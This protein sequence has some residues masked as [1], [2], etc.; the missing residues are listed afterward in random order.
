MYDIKQ[1]LFT[2]ADFHVK[3]SARSLAFSAQVRRFT[4]NVN[5]CK[6]VDVKRYMRLGLNSSPSFSGNVLLVIPYYCLTFSPDLPC[7]SLSCDHCCLYYW[8]ALYF[9]LLL[10]YHALCCLY[11]PFL[12]FVMGLCCWC[13][14]V[15]Y[16]LVLQKRSNTKKIKLG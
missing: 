16:G 14:C 5:R 12:P 15:C 10:L 1:N 2:M 11:C 6:F 7:R 4:C 9:P 8:I 3:I 13:N